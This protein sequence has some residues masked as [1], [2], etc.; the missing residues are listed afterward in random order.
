MSPLQPHRRWLGAQLTVADLD[1]AIAD[2]VPNCAD[3]LP[4]PLPT[5]PDHFGATARMPGRH[6]PLFTPTRIQ[7]A[8]PASAV[9]DVLFAIALGIAGALA[10]FAWATQS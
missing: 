8:K 7:G 6:T 3:S 4:Y 1:A 10:L 5:E 2:K 9:G